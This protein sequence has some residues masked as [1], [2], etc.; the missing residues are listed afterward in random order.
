[1]KIH[2]TFRITTITV[3]ILLCTGIVFSLYFRMSATERAG[4][5]DLYTLVPGGSRVIVDTENMTGLMLNINDLTCSK[6]T[7]FLYFS[8]FFCY[9]KDHINTLIGH[10]PHGLSRQMNRMLISFHEPGG[11]HDQVFYCRLDAGDDKLI[12]EFIHT[13]FVSSFPSRFFDYRGEEIRIYP[14]SGDLFLACYVTSEFLVVSFQKKLVEQV[15]DARLSERS[16]LSDTCFSRIRKGRRTAAPAT[17]YAFMQPVAMGKESDSLRCEADLGGWAEFHVALNGDAI[18]LSG[19]SHD[20]DSCAATFTNTLRGLKPVE[21]FPGRTLPASAFLVSKASISDPHR[22]P[23]FTSRHTRAKIADPDSMTVADEAMYTFLREHAGDE[24]TTC[25]F[26]SGDTADATPCA[27]MSIPLR[28]LSGVRQ[29]L[30]GLQPAGRRRKG[31][32]YHLPRNTLL[33]RL[34][35][36]AGDS[37]QTYARL[38]RNSLLIA[39]H[40]EDLQAYIESVEREETAPDSLLFSEEITATLSQTYT[41]IMMVD[42]EEALRQPEDYV[43]PIPGLFFRYSR[44]FRHFLLT[45]QFTCADDAVYPNVILTY[46]VKSYKL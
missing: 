23:G 21:D 44:F 6:D 36:I 20:A 3:I 26:L 8:R 12:E 39:P 22:L 35:G 24:A 31:D 28:N 41:Y 43:R 15:I 7:H 4:E 18:H 46:K 33:A 13:Y 27:V 19:I 14:M 9:L 42:L 32:T 30:A 38:H 11:D 40:A 25:T 37:L 10:T 17:I 5:F 45:V 29:A 16:I 1:M 34:T 2:I